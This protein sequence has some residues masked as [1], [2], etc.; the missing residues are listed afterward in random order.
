MAS[1]GGLDVTLQSARGAV[2]KAKA[3][4]HGNYAVA[5]LPG[6]EYDLIVSSGERGHL[7]HFGGRFQGKVSVAR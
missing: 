3:D 6:G 2:F 1:T 4:E 5:D 7:T